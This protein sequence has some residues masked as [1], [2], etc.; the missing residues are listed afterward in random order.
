[1][2]VF[3][4]SYHDIL[5]LTTWEAEGRW[6]EALARLILRKHGIRVGLALGSVRRSNRINN[7]LGLFVTDFY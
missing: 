7:R 3:Y 4:S 2:L 1:M 5:V 6:M